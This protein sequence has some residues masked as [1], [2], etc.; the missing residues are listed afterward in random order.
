M[1]VEDVVSLVKIQQYTRYN[2]RDGYN[3]S[4]RNGRRVVTKVL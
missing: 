1:N 3:R 4:D 2:R